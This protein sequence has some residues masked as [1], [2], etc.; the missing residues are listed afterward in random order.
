Y[1][2][3]SGASTRPRV[4]GQPESAVL[5]VSDRS[6]STP[7]GPLSGGVRERSAAARS[8]YRFYRVSTTHQSRI[9]AMQAPAGWEYFLHRSRSG[10]CSDGLSLRHVDADQG[11]EGVSLWPRDSTRPHFSN[12]AL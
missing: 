7:D 10:N 11:S 2:R 4:S 9:S 12:L 3:A 6:W 1:R 8:R 5:R